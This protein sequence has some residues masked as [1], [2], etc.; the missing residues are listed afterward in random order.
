MPIGVTGT[1][2]FYRLFCCVRGSSVPLRGRVNRPGSLRSVCRGRSALLLP[3]LRCASCRAS[4]ERS[5]ALLLVVLAPLRPPRVRRASS[6]VASAPDGSFSSGRSTSTAPPAGTGF[7]QIG[8]ALSGCGLVCGVGCFRLATCPCPAL[9]ERT[10]NLAGVQAAAAWSGG[11]VGFRRLR[12]HQNPG[13]GDLPGKDRSPT[14]ARRMCAALGRIGPTC[15]VPAVRLNFPSHRRLMNE[16]V[17][18]GA[19]QGHVLHGRRSALAERG[20][21]VGV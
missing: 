19:E 6:S 20:A 5:L 1:Q 17:M 2:A 4:Y 16:H 13:T 12:P 10:R 18:F 21:V 8:G 3:A 15:P 14:S 11:G 9:F 7:R